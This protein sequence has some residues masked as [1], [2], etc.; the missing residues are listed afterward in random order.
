MRYFTVAEANALIPTLERILAEI[1]ER[2]DEVSRTTERLQILDVL[3]G[4]R[5]LAEGNPDFAE[6]RDLRTAITRQM[7]EIGEIVEEELNGRGLRFP[8]GGL[9]HGLIDFPTTW[10]GRVVYLCWRLG[11]RGIEAWHEVDG[12]FAGRQPLTPEQIRGMGSAESGT[13]WQ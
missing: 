3:W 5:L 13:P 11:E 4:P 1:R 12:G 2:M 8:Q 9:E 10:E 6:G 7:A